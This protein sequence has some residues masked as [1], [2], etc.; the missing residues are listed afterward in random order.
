MQGKRLVSKRKEGWGCSVVVEHL[1]RTC[2]APASIS[3][4][5]W[6]VASAEVYT[7]NNRMVQQKKKIY[8]RF[9]PQWVRSTVPYKRERKIRWAV[10]ISL[11]LPEDD[12]IWE[13]ESGGDTMVI[14]LCLWQYFQSTSQHGHLL[15]VRSAENDYSFKKKDK[16]VQKKGTDTKR[17]NWCIYIHTYTHTIGNMVM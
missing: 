10:C 2:K 5:L 17:I 1:S 12:S 11:C 15:R 13:G 8:H 9:T 3:S 16:V 4:H 14:P 6:M 7:K